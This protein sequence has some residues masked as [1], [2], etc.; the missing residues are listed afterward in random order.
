MARFGKVIRAKVAT[1]SRLPA[2]IGRKKYK[3]KKE[4]FLFFKMRFG[5]L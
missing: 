4:Y 2:S 5:V 3:K 1:S